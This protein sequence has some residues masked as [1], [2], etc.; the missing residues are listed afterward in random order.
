MERSART[1]F[2]YN[3]SLKADDRDIFQLFS[4]AGTVLDV[5]LIT[6]RSTRRSKGFAYVGAC[7]TAHAPASNVSPSSSVVPYRASHRM[8]CLILVPLHLDRCF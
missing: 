5:K 1:V 8:K 3:L 2:A 7:R 6:D 4:R